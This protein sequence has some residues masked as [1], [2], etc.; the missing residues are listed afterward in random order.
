MDDKGWRFPT[1]EEL[2]EA[3]T[4]GEAFGTKDHLYDFSRIREIYFKADPDYSGRF[5]V[6]V[7]WDKKLQTIVNN[8]SSEILRML[9]TEFNGVI[10]SQH[11]E[12]D[13]YPKE[14]QSEIDEL[15]SWIYD[16]INNGVYK[17]GF[18]T[19]QEVYEKEA[20]NVFTHLDRVEKVL[21]TNQEKDSTHKFLIG[22]SLTEADVRLYTTIVRFDPV[23]HQHFK[24][25][26]KM[27]RHDYPFIHDWLRLLYWKIPGF[28]ETTNFDHIKKH[29]TKSHIAINPHGIT[30]IGPEENI[31]PL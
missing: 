9:N 16:N 31:L 5:T 27:I 11:A 4:N 15:N 14:L 20:H 8:E 6:P 17:S 21:K 30:P 10:D 1:E 19:T 25:N 7:L 2:S 26:W 12:V 3:G 18:A 13:L 22:N 28:K 24:C 23:Y 29:Y